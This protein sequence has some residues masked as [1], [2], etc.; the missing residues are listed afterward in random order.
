MAKLMFA[1]L[2][3]GV[4]FPIVVFSTSAQVFSISVL[5]ALLLTW[6]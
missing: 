3:G 2:P 6:T 1:S 4:N 5:E